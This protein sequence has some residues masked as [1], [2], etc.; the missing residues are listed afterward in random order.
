MASNERDARKTI[1]IT[2]CSSGIGLDAA[3]TLDKLGWRVFAACRQEKD[4]LRLRS[5]HGLATCLIDYT[6]PRPSSP[7]WH[8]S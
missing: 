7:D 4:V 2:G 6:K 8:T 3:L 1:L 5:E